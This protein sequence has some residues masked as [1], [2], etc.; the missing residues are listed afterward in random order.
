MNIL[1]SSYGKDSHACL[2]ACEHLGIKIDRIVHFDVWA[3]DTIPADLP[4]VV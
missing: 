4:P 2:G 1:Y 3:T